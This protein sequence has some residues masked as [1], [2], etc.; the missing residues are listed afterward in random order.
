MNNLIVVLLVILGVALIALPSYRVGFLRG[1]D[2]QDQI[3]SAIILHDADSFIEFIRQLK[4]DP[5]F[6][7]KHFKNAQKEET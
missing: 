6:R 2:Y 7:S 4:N 5:T 1:Q 3:L